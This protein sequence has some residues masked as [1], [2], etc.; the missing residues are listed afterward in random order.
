MALLLLV[1]YRTTSGG[2]EH[3]IQAYERTRNQL[4]AIYASQ[5]PAQ[6]P[7]CRARCGCRSPGAGTADP[8]VLTSNTCGSQVGVGACSD[9]SPE[10]DS[11]QTS[12]QPGSVQGWRSRSRSDAAGALDRFRLAWILLRRVR[13]RTPTIPPAYRTLLWV[14]Q[15]RSPGHYAVTQSSAHESCLLSARLSLR[16]SLASV[17]SCLTIVNTFRPQ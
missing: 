8:Y 9:P 6:R 16:E 10:P 3:V 1:R 7:R 17:P 15:A 4:D 2:R 11:C 14:V 13:G 5:R 12:R